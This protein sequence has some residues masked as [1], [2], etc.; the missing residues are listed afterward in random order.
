MNT[1][2]L[3]IIQYAVLLSIPLLCALVVW[4]CYQLVRSLPTQQ[5]EA[6]EQFA[7]I[8]VQKVEQQDSTLSGTAKKQL[9]IDLVVKLF[10][11]FKIPSPPVEMIDVAIEA[12]VFAVNQVSMMMGAD[13]QSDPSPRPTDA[14]T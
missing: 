12:A 11:T 9:A 6:L 3:P 1:L 7:R 8:A 4:L 5:R 2:I 10:S 13:K 14:T